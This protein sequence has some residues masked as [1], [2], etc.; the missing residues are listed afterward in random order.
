MSAL[1]SL[2]ESLKKAANNRPL[3]KIAVEAGLPRDAVRSV[4]N[5]HDPRLS[6][7]EAVAKA[8]NLEVRI[9]NADG[10][11]EDQG[12]LTLIPRFDIEVSAGAGALIG[13]EDQMDA[14]PI[15]TQ[16]VSGFGVPRSSLHFISV[17][18]DSMHPTLSDGTL[19]LV[20]THLSRPADG[21][22][23]LG[24]DE[25]ILV[26]RVEFREKGVIHLISDNAFY[27]R[28]IVENP[29]E[30]GLRILARAIWSWRKL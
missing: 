5:G 10:F 14:I 11:Q 20:T 21:I 8:V 4:L 17:R 19:L 6:R 15:P 2:R 3:S 22:Y 18:G 16:L 24:W 13:S 26:K 7:A 28:R 30:S 12:N 9:G 25:I 27:E 23:V 1:N 29:E